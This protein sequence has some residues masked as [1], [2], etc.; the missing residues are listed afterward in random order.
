M[1]VVHVDTGRRWR[2]GQQQVYFLHRELVARG[3]DST[4]VCPAGSP[5]HRRC[6]EEGLPV[7]GA[8]GGVLGRWGAWRALRRVLPGAAILHVHDS[9]GL[10][11]GAWAKAT[12]WPGRLVAHR[13][14][15]YRPGRNP[16]SRWKYAA[17]DAWI[18][19]SGEVG[20]ALAEA[21]VAPERVRVVPSAIDREALERGAA[22]V[23]GSEVRRRWEVPPGSPVVGMCGAFSPQKGHRVLLDAVPRVLAVHPEVVFVLVGEGELR[24]A[25]AVRARALGIEGAIR[26][27]GFEPEAAALTA[28]FAVAVVPSVDGEGSSAAIKEAMALGVPAVVSDLPGNREVVG[29]AGVVVPRGRPEPLAQAIVGLLGNPQRRRALGEKG[30]DRA[31]VFSVDAMADGVLAAY[32]AAGG[33]GR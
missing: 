15:S 28:L 6:A 18:A 17:V 33:A 9:H 11:L 2:G 31:E 32:R 29:E 21:G 13:R 26:L 19:V 24:R 22:T 10:A 25:A 30:K 7:Q 23:D 8:P 20:Q 1:T 27:P 4:L 16:L 3:E 14:V 12:G 5:L